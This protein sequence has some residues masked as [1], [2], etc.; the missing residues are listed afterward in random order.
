[1]CAYSIKIVYLQK[2]ININFKKTGDMVLQR[3]QSVYL[4]VAS[5]LM[6]VYAFVPI[7]ELSLDSATIELTMRGAT[8]IDNVGYMWAFFAVSVLVSL[9]SLVTIFKYKNLKLQKRM[10]LISGCLTVALLV[11]LMIVVIM[12]SCLS[13]SLT[14]YNAIPVIAVIMYYLADCGISKDQK[15]LSGY[16]R[17]R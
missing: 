13:Y 6:M 16:D 12:I 10:C 2:I 9:F 7:A 14:A 8:G 3:W 4:L 1:M 11:S 15:I 5:I 17:I